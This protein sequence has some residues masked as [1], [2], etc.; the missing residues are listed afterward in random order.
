MEIEGRPPSTPGNRLVTDVTVTDANFFRAMQIQLKRGRFYTPQ[1]VQ[2][3]RHV[4]VVNEAFA[5]KYF[6]NEEPLGKRV[7]IAMM[8]TPAPCEIIGVVGNVKNHKLDVEA[9]PMAYWPMSELTYSAMSLVVRAKGDPTEL[10][11]A[12][13]NVIHALDPQQPVAEVRTLATVLG[14][15]IA[16]ERFS[17]LLLT[18]FAVVA[19]LLSA[20]G[21]Y[22]VMAY[23]VTQR[24]HEIGIRAALGATAADILRLVL[25]QGMALALIGVGVGLLAAFGLT[26]L[27]E[28]LLFN[29][30]ATDAPTFASIAVLLA[31]VALLACFV[32][33]WRATKV[34]PLVA[35]RYE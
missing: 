33:A 21:I 1:E 20:I 35:L 19:L 25:R 31:A 14:N 29:L 4:V 7:M 3:T 24:T 11:P 2:E 26:R 8:D 17:T 5:Q 15:S 22:G 9:F 23:A 30:S 12:V 34:D 28:T 6:P 13:R 18:V 27:L 10:A 32:P 16:R